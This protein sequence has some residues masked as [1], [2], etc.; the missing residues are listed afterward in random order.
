M[1]LAG[2]DKAQELGGIV[3]RT[4]TVGLL[5]VLGAVTHLAAQRGNP[6][7]VTGIQPL[8]FGTLL[9][10]IPTTIAPTN[11]ASAGRFNLTGSRYE[12]VYLTF[13]LP[14]ALVGPGG[15]KLPLTFGGNSAGFSATQSTGD[16]ILFD[17]SQSYSATLGHK[18]GSVFLGGTANPSTAQTAGS[19]SATVTLTVAFM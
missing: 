16:E 11:G 4:T 14:A 2:P 19:Y 12:S 1:P 17:P 3:M 18:V 7:T 5:L 13:T 9:P 8:A 6:Q 15:A 10:G